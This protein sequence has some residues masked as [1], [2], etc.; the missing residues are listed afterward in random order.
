[1]PGV[2]GYLLD[3]EVNA[4]RLRATDWIPR[5]IQYSTEAGTLHQL[6]YQLYLINPLSLY[7]LLI[8]LYGPSS[9]PRL[10]GLSLAL[11]EIDLIAGTS[12][13][14]YSIKLMAAVDLSVCSNHLSLPILL[15]SCYSSHICAFSLDFIACPC[16]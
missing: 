14:F 7:L 3:V 6:D 8:D 4:P 13:H 15:L 9:W 5:I 16:A 11:T 12:C 10:R 1:M 2:P